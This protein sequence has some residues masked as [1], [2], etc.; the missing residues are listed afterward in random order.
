[1]LGYKIAGYYD[2]TAAEWK[3]CMVF[4]EIP[5]GAIVVRPEHRVAEFPGTFN[6]EYICP[7][8]YS[9]KLRCN[10]A[11]VLNIADLE[12]GHTIDEAIS[13]YVLGKFFHLTCRVLG[14]RVAPVVECVGFAQTIPGGTYSPNSIV[15]PTALDQNVT[16]ECASGIHFFLTEE[17][18]KNFYET[19]AEDGVRSWVMGVLLEAN[20]HTRRSRLL[21]TELRRFYFIARKKNMR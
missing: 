4:L 19:P 2:K 20:T 1:M 10:R 14:Q 13:I 16:E 7:K 9:K 17:D 15:N 5:D 21:P 6:R 12:D 18:A 8:E 3:P 11:S